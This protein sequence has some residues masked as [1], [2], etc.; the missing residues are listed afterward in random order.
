MLDSSK[1]KIG[2]APIGW[3]NDDMPELGGEIPFE[4]CIR[5]M[6][7]TGY[8]GCEIGS[9]FPRDPDVLLNALKPYELKI[10]SQWFSSYFTTNTNPDET[11]DAFKTHMKF[12]KSVGAKVVV[13]SE[14]GYSIQGQMETPLFRNKPVLLEN[15]WEK[16]KLGLERIGMIAIEN[17]MKIAYHHHMGTIVQSRSEI[18]KLMGITNPDLVF[19]LADTG[20]MYYAGGDPNKLVEDYIERI[21]HIHLKDVRANI[22]KKARED[23]LSF[24]QSV[25]MGVF[26][27]PGDGSIDFKPI[28]DTISKSKYHGWLLV[29]AEQDPQ[30]ADPKL[31]AQKGRETILKLTGI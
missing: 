18:D 31:Y 7:E 23:N 16:L 25:K 9:K 2:I 26:T 11:V 13:V 29:E 14:Q 19:L 20:H 4:Q 1:I 8:E 27:V 12:L 3:T 28:F 22:M 24:L 30:L 6:Y 15:D 10:A 5:Q 21:I 17:G